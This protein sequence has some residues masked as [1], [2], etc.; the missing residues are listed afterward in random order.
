MV[1][2]LAVNEPNLVELW[3]DRL[4]HEDDARIDPIAGPHDRA[5]GRPDG[6]E[7]RLRVTQ[8][9][10]RLQLGGVRERITRKTYVIATG[11]ENNTFAPVASKLRQR[12]DWRVEE[13]P[14]THDL[15][16][17][18]TRETVDMIESALP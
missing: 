9:R 13:M 17:V 3:R 1:L 18:A 5:F 2:Y 11:Y 14:Y 4:S 15:M 6:R 16:H 10:I 12:A 7:G 8:G